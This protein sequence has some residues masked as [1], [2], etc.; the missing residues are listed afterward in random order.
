MRKSHQNQVDVEK[1]RKILTDPDF[2]NAPSYGNSLKR[3]QASHP[4]GVP[5]DDISKYLL[6][7][8]EEVKAIHDAACQK[9]REYLSK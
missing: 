6:V 7:S 2:I 4:E 3:V 9:I 8:K 5:E 1:K